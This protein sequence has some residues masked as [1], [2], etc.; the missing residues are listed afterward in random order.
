MTDFRRWLL[1][2]AFLSSFSSLVSAQP[3][4]ISTV[5]GGLPAPTAVPA[6]PYAFESPNGVA[7]DHFGNTYISTS[8]NCVFR[9]DPKGNLSRVAGNC[10]QGFSGDGGNALN[11]QL[12]GP[13]GIAVDLL[14]NL[15]IVDQGNQ[16]LRQVS[17]SGIITTVAGTGTAGYNGDNISATGA[18]LKNPQ[19]VAVDASGNVYVADTGNFRI[20]KVTPGG[21][22]TTVAGT[23]ASGNSGN[24]GAATSAK[25]ISPGGLAVDSNG[26]LYVSDAGAKQVRMINSAGTIF[27]FAGSGT[28]GNLG[29]SGP[30]ISATLANPQGLSVDGAGNV[31]IAD[32]AIARVRKVD[33]HGVITTYAGNGVPGYGGDSGPAVSAQ[34]GEPVSVA[35]DSAGGLYIADLAGVVRFV[36]VASNISTVAGSTSALPFSGDGG[37]AAIAAFATPRGLARDGSGNLYIADWRGNRVRKMN[38]AGTVS[39]FAGNGSVG[40]AGDGQPAISASVTPFVVTVDSTGNVYLA[41]S[42]VIRKVNL[43]GVISTIAGTGVFGYN[44]DNQPA[45]SATLNSYLPGIAVDS[46]QNVF[47]ADWLNQRVREVNATTGFI[48][49]V[50]GNG[51]PGYAGDGH[52]ATSASLQEPAGLALDTNGN[53][54]IADYGNCAVR[55]LSATDGSISTVAGNG[56]CGSTGDGQTATAAEIT[57]PWAV[58]LDA[59]GNLYIS[60]DANTIRKVSAGGIIST[61]AGTGVAGYSGDGGLATS[62]QLNGPQGLASDPAGNIYVADF[63]NSAIRVLQPQTEPLLTVSSVHS[64]PFTLG[65]NGVFQI[66][67]SNAPQ[68]ASTAGTVTV[69]V[70]LS[71]GV[72]PVSMGGSGWSCSFSTPPYSCTTSGLLNGG[73]S[74]GQV[75]LT[76]NVASGAPAQI[77]SQLLVSGGGSLGA[78][79]EDVAFIGAANP[80]LSVTATHSGNFV[81]GT[82]ATFTINV[83][84]QAWA[85]STS[86]PVTVTASPSSGLNLVSMSG[87]GWNCTGASCVNTAVLKGGAGLNPITGTVGVLASASSPQTNTANLTGGGSAPASSTDTIIILSNA[88]LLTG[89]NT[90]GVTDVQEAINES[91]GTKSP[92]HD[93]NKDGVVNLVDAQIV[94]NAALTLGC[95]SN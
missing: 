68:A 90:V 38:S 80:T 5:A 3:Y 62:A 36:N 25:F 46:H 31:Y 44:G 74:Y 41:D 29:D 88:C 48:T 66:T 86:S 91:L 22:I 51:T 28:S 30:A 47:I 15:Y 14:G 65:Q 34:L 70:L 27:A 2:A 95:S 56:T 63:A 79:F 52:A 21:I 67:V 73:Q 69:A 43:S 57:H 76:V 10:Q 42:G 35:A 12:N 89:G 50:A 61:I 4:L 16:R 6:N 93:V 94:I 11:A 39:T 49:T 58:A 81:A 92:L 83:G 40:D 75:T 37:P 45:T 23:G 60:T 82:Q 26:N 8:Y 9:L 53:L 32:E 87:T 7:T 13:Q 18:Q 24:G 72:T 33:V 85:P 77:T 17:L 19:G 55:R 59:N 20:R 64:D 71:S 1:A 78:S 84:N 54:Y